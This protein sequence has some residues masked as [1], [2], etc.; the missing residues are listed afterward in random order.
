MKSLLRILIKLFLLLGLILCPDPTLITTIPNSPTKNIN[1]CKFDYTNGKFWI[2]GFELNTKK[3]Y[4]FDLGASPS[5]V[6]SY[7]TT[8]PNEPGRLEMIEPNH[9]LIAGKRGIHLRLKTDP[10]TPL[11]PGVALATAEIASVTHVL[12]TNFFCATTKNTRVFHKFDYTTMAEV[13][14]KDD[15]KIPWDMN[16]SYY[17]AGTNFY[18]LGGDDIFVTGVDYTNLQITSPIV[19]STANVKYVESNDRKNEIVFLT[20]D[21]GFT[22]DVAQG[23]Y[24]NSYALLTHGKNKSIKGVLYTNVKLVFGRVEHAVYCV[25]L[26]DNDSYDM[27][28]KYLTNPFTEN[29]GTWKRDSNDFCYNPVNNRFMINNLLDLRIL[30]DSN[31]SVSCIGAPI[32]EQCR[33]KDNFCVKCQ[34]GYKLKYGKCEILCGEGFFYENL[35]KLCRAHSCDNSQHFNGSSCFSCG[36]DQYLIEESATCKD[37]KIDYG[38][39][40][41]ECN[42]NSCKTCKETFVLSEDKKSCVCPLN[43]K[44]ENG[45]CICPGNFKL[46]N[47]ECICPQG[48][49]IE[50]GKCLCPE[51]F[52]LENK[53]CVCKKP[54]CCKDNEF[55]LNKKCY[56]NEGIKIGHGLYK[57]KI[58]KSIAPCWQNNCKLCKEDYK[59]CKDDQSLSNRVDVLKNINNFIRKFTGYANTVLNA[60]SSMA[61]MVGIDS[62]GVLVTSTQNLKLL[63]NL[64]FINLNFGKNIEESE[65]NKNKEKL[66]KILRL[67]KKTG[68]KLTKFN[69]DFFPDITMG[70][71][72]MIYYLCW[73]IK[74]YIW[75]L[76]TIFKEK[77]ITKKSCWTIYILKKIKFVIFNAS[78]FEFIF[79]QS[80]VLLHLDLNKQNGIMFNMY[81]LMVSG[82]ML[83]L[84]F[85]ILKVLQRIRKIKQPLLIEINPI[86]KN[87]KQKSDTEKIETEFLDRSATLNFVQ[88]SNYP[89]DSFILSEFNPNSSSKGFKFF[90]YF[91]LIHYLRASFF[92]IF[93]T[94]LQQ[95][96]VVSVCAMILVEVFCFLYLMITQLKFRYLNWITF[97][98][99]LL[100]HLSLSIFLVLAYALLSDGESSIKDQGIIILTMIAV[101]VIENLFLCINFGKIVFIQF[102]FKFSKKSR[103]IL[104]STKEKVYLKKKI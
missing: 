64:K 54:I 74:I 27:L 38:D 87:S 11:T 31:S 83:L 99:K 4:E 91:K 73:I 3:T 9:L 86:K 85:D 92:M 24:I 81:Y 40:C 8:E 76:L 55:Y 90:K 88:N 50:E 101:F 25:D 82:A 7:G 43:F 69:I 103:Y 79:F 60:A 72:M 20:N 37:C 1:I 52:K 51:N 59:I 56:P 77:A 48:F 89:L 65:Q 5:I 18:F 30:E 104:Q 75:I 14:S 67:G 53:Q 12:G 33:Y 61:L 45:K 15:P 62:E 97:T 94:S 17:Q 46:E 21:A 47:G 58:G 39:E 80:R 66:N 28:W 78:F 100:S 71:K 22:V 16:N 44:L 49:K 26:K 84:V 19:T 68:D 6:Q 41:L 42:Y 96:V 70:I 2:I 102:W 35:T 93:I 13:D 36:S 29:S 23:Q 95:L 32:C 10:S 57:L 63:G 98:H 34:S